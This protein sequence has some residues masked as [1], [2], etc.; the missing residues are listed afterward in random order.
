[1]LQRFNGAPPRPSGPRVY[2][3]VLTRGR[4]FTVAYW[5]RSLVFR[6]GKAVPITEAEYQRLKRVAVA[7]PGFVTDGDDT[8]QRLQRRRN[9]FRFTRIEDGEDVTPP[10]PED[11]PGPEPAEV[12]A[13]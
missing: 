13:A 6:K 5:P 1:M 12:E 4:T 3:A 9:A 7:L 2:Q 11:A 10:E 8:G